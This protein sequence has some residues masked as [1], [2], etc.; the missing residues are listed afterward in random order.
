MS[1]QILFS[2]LVLFTFSL[3]RSQNLPHTSVQSGTKFYVNQL[4]PQIALCP[5]DATISELPGTS[6]SL[7]KSNGTYRL[8]STVYEIPGDEINSWTTNMRVTYTYD[9]VGYILQRMQY[10]YG[11]NGVHIVQKDYTNDSLGRVTNMVQKHCVSGVWAYQWDN[12]WDY[13]ENGFLTQLLVKIH[14]DEWTD[15]AIYY[16]SY[17]EWGFLSEVMNYHWSGGQWVNQQI[18]YYQYDTT[19]KILSHASTDWW[20]NSYWVNTFKDDYV[21]NDSENLVSLL[22]YTWWDEDW[23]L[24]DT[25]AWVWDGFNNLVEKTQVQIQNNYGEILDHYEY[26][27][28]NDYTLSD[29]LLPSILKDTDLYFRHMLTGYN[30]YWWTDLDSVNTRAT[31]HYSGLDTGWGEIFTKNVRIFPNPVGN[32]IVIEC[33]PG[34]SI[35]TAEIADLRGNTVFRSE[36]FSQQSLKLDVKPLPPGIY[37]VRIQ[38]NKGILNEKI[39]KR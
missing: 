24:S 37:I 10:E 39:V 26:F 20:E 22:N 17:D 4:D 32:A 2:A 23:H 15:W 19:G 8:D 28:N 16:Y 25:T 21:Y 7:F 3:L 18:D 29:L 35:H 27:Y 9:S 13:D 14:L 30:Y 36:I 31:Y 1:K 12:T 34:T 5:G 11:T 33:K 38:T 6:P